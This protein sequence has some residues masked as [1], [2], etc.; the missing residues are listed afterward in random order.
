M[1]TNPCGATDGRARYITS[2]AILLHTQVCCY[3]CV[4]VCVWRRLCN[5][6]RCMYQK[7][8]EL[9]DLRLN[10]AN[11]P[12][13]ACRTDTQATRLWNASDVQRTSP[14]IPTSPY[15]C[16]HQSHSVQINNISTPVHPRVSHD[17]DV[18]A[19]IKA[20]T[21]MHGSYFCTYQYTRAYE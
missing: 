2:V 9:E 6:L 8:L 17:Q 1:N 5:K 4:C 21:I 3:V 18:T 12:I 14:S 15:S 7:Q 19:H 16:M 20:T 13:E 10:A 11:H